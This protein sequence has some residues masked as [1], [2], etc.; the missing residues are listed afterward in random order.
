MWQTDEKKDY[1]LI[2]GGLTDV[3]R[4]SERGATLAVRSPEAIVPEFQ[5]G[6]TEPV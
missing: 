3:S 5:Q 1:I 4:S 2:W 6:R